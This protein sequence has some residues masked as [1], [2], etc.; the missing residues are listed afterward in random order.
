[1]KIT[2][3]LE[4]NPD[5][6]SRFRRLDFPLFEPMSQGSEDAGR[7]LLQ[8]ARRRKNLKDKQQ[9]LKFVF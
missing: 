9:L 3:H 7:G 2:A 1:M 4:V 6:V 5:F 8:R